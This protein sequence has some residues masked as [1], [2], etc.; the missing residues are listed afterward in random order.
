[1]ARKSRKVPGLGASTEVAE[2][3]PPGSYLVR[4]A[5]AEYSYSFRK[6]FLALTFRVVEPLAFRNQAF[7][8]RQ[9][10]TAKELWKLSWF[11]RDFEYSRA[12]LDDDE[13]D[14]RRLLGREG[15][16]K[17]SYAVLDRFRDV[18]LEAFAPAHCWEKLVVPSALVEAS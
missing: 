16:V 5:K 11:L 17:V 13:L 2:E 14:E 9:Y 12:L 18:S 3:L 4:V 8:S 7:N 15:I 10:C 6:P 1:M